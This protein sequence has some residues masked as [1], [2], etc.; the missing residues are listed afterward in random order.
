VILQ[1][2]AVA[3]AGQYLMEAGAPM[4]FFVVA[5]YLRTDLTTERYVVTTTESGTDT[6]LTLVLSR[7]KRHVVLFML[8]LFPS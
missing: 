7:E 1:A 3:R 5:V 8:S 2:T 4:R 6:D